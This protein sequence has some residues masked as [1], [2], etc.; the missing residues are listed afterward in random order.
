MA[1][2]EFVYRGKTFEQIKGMDLKEFA[3]MLPARQRRSILRGFSEEQKRLLLKIKKAK[4]GK[5]KKNIRTHCRDMIVI[6][7]MIGVLVYVHAGK[8]FVP[9][10]LQPDTLGFYLGELTMTRNRVTHSAP[11]IGATKS[12]AAASVK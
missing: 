4:E 8:T 2:K 9:I 6:P 12:S 3:E 10:D 5:F 1:R 7:E 11:G